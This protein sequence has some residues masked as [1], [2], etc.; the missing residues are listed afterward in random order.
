LIPPIYAIWDG[1]RFVP[2][3]R[4]KA[5]TDRLQVGKVYRIEIKD[6]ASAKSRAFFHAR[7][8][9][10]WLSLPE[11]YASQYPNVD[12][13]RAH[14]LVATGFTNSRQF[15][16]ETEMGA[17]RL[18]R[19]LMAP[20]TDGSEPK[21]SVVSATGCVVTELTAK[22]QSPHSMDTQEFNESKQKVLEY[23][24]SLVGVRDAT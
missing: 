8:R 2:L 11:P 1:E 23:V 13:L 22:S 9:E 24:E 5:E 12:I 16:C 18:K 4:H 17:R 3:K 6:E 19:W 20:P 21:Y 7:L 15:I 14:A 10:L